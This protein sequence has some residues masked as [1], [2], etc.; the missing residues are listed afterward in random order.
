MIQKL[1]HK[2]AAPRH[3]WRTMKFDELAEIYTSMTMRSLGFGI[4]GIF[5][6]VF[7][8]KSGVDLQSVFYFYAIFF[9]LRVPVSFATAF[10]VGRIGPK[11]TIAISTVVFVVFLSLLLTFE[12]YD[13]PLAVMALF[14]TIANGLFFVAYNTD[15]SKVNHSK[16]GGKELGW[17]YIFERAGFALGPVVGGL[18]ASYIS[19]EL[20]IVVAVLV[21]LASLVPLFM[22]NEPV[23]LHQKIDFKGFKPRKYTA[24][25]TALAAFNI[26]NVASTIMWPLLV[27]VFIFVEDTYAKLGGVIGLG[28]VISIFSARMF[29]KFIDNKKGL[30]LLQY[31]VTMDTVLHLIRPFITTGAGAVAVSTSNEPITLSYKMPLVKGWYDQADTVEGYRIVYL[32]WSEMI[33]GFSKGIYCLSLFIACYFWDPLSVL[34]YNFFFIALIALVMLIQRFPAIKR[35]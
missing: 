30:Y 14:F 24:N 13:W 15:F 4:I 34:R 19:P 25:F 10:I 27:G 33:T 29:G 5:V 12:I 7:L 17:L 18:I 8:Y 1:I 2:I 31:G 20:T 11:H 26:E 23:K 21:M 16:H 28:M 35:V 6:P 3:P 22:T 9:L 32:T